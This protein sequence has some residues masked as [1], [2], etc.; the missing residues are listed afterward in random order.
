MIDDIERLS[1]LLRGNSDFQVMHS[2]E[3]ERF[4]YSQSPKHVFV[5]CSDSRVSP[6]LITKSGIGEIFD[7]RMI[8]GHLG[9][10]SLASVEFAVS[11]FNIEN[12]VV[13]GHSKCSAVSAAQ[14]M[15]NGSIRM[16]EQRDSRGPAFC[17]LVSSIAS[18][19]SKN[20]ENLS[21]LDTAV[22]DNARAQAMTLINNQAVVNAMS[23]GMRLYVMVYN[24]ERGSLELSE[25]WHSAA[26]RREAPAAKRS[27]SIG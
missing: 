23:K 20:P 11:G 16:D 10:E 7:V 4:A 26:D 8:G 15:L 22:M 2:R 24:L 13:L 18:N 27:K 17:D 9:R 12:L 19:I 3:I 21:N 1:P 25:R 14:K 6:E 5:A